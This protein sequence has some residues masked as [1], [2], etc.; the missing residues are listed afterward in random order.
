M[1]EA[2]PYELKQLPN[3]CCFKHEMIDGRKT[4]IPYDPSTGFKAKSNDASTWVDFESA[5]SLSQNYDGLGFFFS[6]PY[7]GID[8]DDVG[9]EIKQYQ[10]GSE[11]NIISEFVDLLE[12]YA[13][14]S[15]SGNG[16]H[17]ILKG[18]LP[19]DGRRKG[20]IEMYPSGRFFTMTGNAIGGYIHIND[21]RDMNRLG[22]LHAKYIKTSAPVTTQKTI[23]SEGNDLS[24][25]E[26]ISIAKSSS[27]TGLRFSA[28]VDGGW[29][30]FYTSQSEADMAFANDL[31]FWCAR[32]Y[33]KMDNIYR[34]SSLM[35]DKWDSKRAD[36]TYG[37]ETL[38]KAISECSNV[39]V[40][41]PKDDDFS[42]TVVDQSVKK[43]ERKFYSYDDTGNAER[44]KD[45]HGDILKYS[46]VR[47][48]WFYYD[49]K[50]WQIDQ[51]GNVKT[52]ADETIEKMKNERPY[53]SGDVSE[54]D[55]RELLQKHIKRTRNSAGKE[56]MIKEA[57]HLLPIDLS[58][59]DQDIHL[60]NLQNGY[61]DLETGSVHEHDKDKFFTRISNVEYDG[62]HAAPMWDKFLKEIFNNDSELIEYIQRAIGYSLSGS[63]EEQMMFIL[64][65][66]G[67]NGKS[68]FLDLVTELFGSYATNIQPQ[69]IM[70]KQQTSNANP[71]IAKLDGAR[72]VTTTEP[73]EGVRMDEGLVKQLTGGD[74]VSARFLYE[75]EFEFIPQFKLWMATNHKPIIRGTDDGIW[76]RM[77]IIPFT[78]QIP[79]HKVDKRLTSKLKR[80]LKGIMHW[81]VEGYLKWSKYGLQEPAVVKEQRKEY[82]SEMDVLEGFIDECCIIR[83]S[84]KVKASDVY[85]A[86]KQWARDNEQY[87]MSST[88]FGRELSKKFMRF[89]SGTN[90]YKGISIRKEAEKA[91]FQINY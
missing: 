56:N 76:R 86:Y 78:V 38:N 71:D 36:S 51:Y 50:V 90:Y 21:D 27:K 53:T 70:V 54:E 18:E 19:P 68:V 58:T 12:S 28:F 66:H 29:E 2:I 8:I 62:T 10:Q 1:Y 34:Q 31:A 13:E 23:E 88:K 75:D 45:D 43:V 89:K 61:L 72:F 65:G 4:K 9:E 46:Y 57:Q 87:L 84:E 15:P 77:A 81:A 73:N 37:A 30:Q 59:F 44:Y 33:R 39:F 82:R 14:I 22:Y 20:N 63:T 32:D 16:I 48:N 79:E 80:E 55:A 60:F 47:K 6:E 64:Y 3:W 11:D 35:R 67:R 74:K 7:V 52:L 5:L 17:I 91:V 40:P 24:E 26:I 42:L 41:Q 25:S 69:S 85:Q 49:G 83:D